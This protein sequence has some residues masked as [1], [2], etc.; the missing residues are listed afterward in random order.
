M[1]SEM[2]IRDRYRRVQ[3]LA[4]EFAEHWKR[5]MY[6]IGDHRA[7]WNEESRNAQVGDLVLIMEK[8][9]K[10]LKR[11]EWITGTITEA[12]PDSDGL[13]RTVT[14]QPHKRP[15]ERKERRPKK[16]S[17]H[18]LVLLKE[19]HNADSSQEMKLQEIEDGM[20]RKEVLL[21]VRPEEMSPELDLQE[22]FGIEKIE[23]KPLRPNS[24]PAS[25]DSY[26]D[27]ELEYL[28]TTAEQVLDKI[29]REREV[30][31]RPKD[32]SKNEI[33]HKPPARQSWFRRDAKRFKA[34]F[35]KKAEQVAK[36]FLKCCRSQP[37][38]DLLEEIQRN[39]VEEMQEQPP[40][41]SVAQPGT[42]KGSRWCKACAKEGSVTGWHLVKNCPHLQEVEQRKEG[43]IAENLLTTNAEVYEERCQF[44]A[45][46]S[47]EHGIFKCPRLGEGLALSL[48]HI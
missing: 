23:K 21:T 28:Q 4:D 3:A 9:Y 13:V 33:T 20:M 8:D 46:P 25:S 30:P 44:C 18:Y 19:V 15:N 48:I 12:L 7:K 5:Y 37:D 27:Q 47:K 34:M 38:Y 42:G 45:A 10:K 39:E 16:M 14:V 36:V 35:Q 41:V 43:N 24:R 29:S 40:E 1:G 17:I 6:E 26:T 2:C 11:L 31:H 22:M 32:C